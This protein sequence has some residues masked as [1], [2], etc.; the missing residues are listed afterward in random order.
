MMNME[1]LV[2][3]LTKGI[4]LFILMFCFFF[5]LYFAFFSRLLLDAWTSLLAVVQTVAHCRYHH[6]EK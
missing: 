3:Y 2:Y 1:Q 4:H 6:D 5:S